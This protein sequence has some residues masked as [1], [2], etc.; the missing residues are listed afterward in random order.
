M[1]GCHKGSF[2]LLSKFGD[3]QEP[4]FT[5]V[6]WFFFSVGTQGHYQYE[7]QVIFELQI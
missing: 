3:Y 7:T 5:E 1:A 2:G 4:F 6:C